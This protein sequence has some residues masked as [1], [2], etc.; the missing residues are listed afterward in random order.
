MDIKII[1]WNLNFAADSNVEL[2]SFV[3]DAFENADIL[4]FT[5]CKQ[6]TIL[7]EILEGQNYKVF[8]SPE[9]K[10]FRN[11][12]I[13]AVKDYLE[14]DEAPILAKE[15]LGEMPDFLHVQLKIDGKMYHVVG[16]RIRIGMRKAEC[17]YLSRR[18]QFELLTKYIDELENVIVLGDF[19]NGMIKAD[20]ELQYH[21]VKEAYQYIDE[22]NGETEEKKLSLLRFYNFH[23]M[24]EMLGDE[25]SLKEIGGE[26]S[27]WG[28]S[29]YEGELS[30]GLIKNDQVITKKIEVTEAHYDW[31]H[32]REHEREY[33][34]MLVSS[35]NR[36]GNKIK[37]GYPDHA[38][39]VVN[40]NL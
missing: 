9:L 5:E 16:T 31:S 18:N 21:E 14:A 22:T 4:V 7:N 17:D 33:Y 37:H 25:Y 24:K 39:L 38:K 20:S 23:M 26:N 32:V 30:Y 36:R 12:I 11:Q 15:I 35:E 13:I 2:A 1:E 19:N 28:L 3:K 10:G 8:T 6:N 40:V 29:I 34:N 27:S